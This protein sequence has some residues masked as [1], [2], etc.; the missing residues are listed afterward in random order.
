MPYRVCR[1]V[2]RFDYLA[3]RRIPLYGGLK[4]LYALPVY[5]NR[6][7]IMIIM[8]VYDLAIALGN[9]R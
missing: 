1:N 7:N 6:N 4:R 3:R 8:L 2:K 5:A 9:I